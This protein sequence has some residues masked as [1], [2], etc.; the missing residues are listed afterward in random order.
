MAGL[1]VDL[2]LT[3][4]DYMINLSENSIDDGIK[5]NCVPGFNDHGTQYGWN[6]GILFLKKFLIIYDFKNE[7]L[8]F[9]RSNQY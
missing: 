9:V 5:D 8:G 1:T 7:K 4:E 3:P 6:L 2:T